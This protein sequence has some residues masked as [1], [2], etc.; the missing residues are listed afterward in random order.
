MGLGKFTLSA[1]VAMFAEVA[2]HCFLIL[3]IPDSQYF[4]PAIAGLHRCPGLGELQKRK[5]RV[6]EPVTADVHTP[7]QH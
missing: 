6:R 1:V 4:P 7:L 2:D 5:V 3:N